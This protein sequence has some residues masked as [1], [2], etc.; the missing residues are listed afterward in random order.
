M[1]LV[2]FF[3]FNLDLWDCIPVNFWVL[4][5]IIDFLRFLVVLSFRLNKLVSF[6]VLV[7]WFLGLDFWSVKQKLIIWQSCW[8]FFYLTFCWGIYYFCALLICNLMLV[9]HL[10]LRFLLYDVA[11]EISNFI[12]LIGNLINRMVFW[13]GLHLF[14]FPLFNFGIMN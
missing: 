13:H 6:F 4:E 9:F 12:R 11:F 5:L 2:L 10:R 1:L 8:L 7:H 14:Y 3:H